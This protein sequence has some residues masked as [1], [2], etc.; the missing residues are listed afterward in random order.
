MNAEQAVLLRLA[1]AAIRDAQ[2][3]LGGLSPPDWEAVFRLACASKIEGILLGA[4]SQLRREEAPPE[5][6]LL[7]WKNIT[8]LKSCRQ[9]VFGFYEDMLL[10]AF[11]GQGIPCVLF[12]GGVLADLYPEAHTRYSVDTDILVDPADCAGAER[13]LADMGF[14]Y[15]EGISKDGVRVWYLPGKLKV[16]M[17]LRLWED[18]RDSRTEAL[19]RMNLVSPESLI[20]YPRA[21]KTCTTMGH[22]EHLIY[23][24]FHIVKHVTFQGALLR[25]LLDTTLFINRY[26]EEMDMARFWDCMEQLRYTRFCTLMFSACA[27]FFGLDARALPPGHGEEDTEDFLSGIL[28]LCTWN[29]ENNSL[30]VASSAIHH[31]YCESAGA[32]RP[33][34]RAR[35]VMTLLFPGSSL[36][37]ERYA[38]AKRYPALLP[39]AW[40][41][42]AVNSVF[43]K[44]RLPEEDGGLRSSLAAAN[45]KFDMLKKLELMS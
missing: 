44:K 22:T 38:Y 40:M 34:N 9:M 19:E 24:I 17:H 25:N 2:P 4:V 45:R 6:L 8:I 23:Q 30:N 42:R 16:E 18:Y 41:H 31:V 14:S 26:F 33:V 27:D 35:M 37:S 20:A 13:V 32:G 5:E 15:E 7:E 28:N 36:L 10:E 3:D 11:S 39:L 1:A 43:H 12:K 29:R 21:G